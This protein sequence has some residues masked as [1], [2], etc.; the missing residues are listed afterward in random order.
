[1]PCLVAVIA[2]A[3]PRIVLA[4]IFFTSAY[5]DRAFGGN[6]LWPFLGFLFLP[7]TTLAYA[8]AINTAGSVHGLYLVAIIVAVLIDLGILGGSRYRR[9]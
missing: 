7:L 9:G 1:M 3:F 5:L 2:L 6:Y 8:Y 4:L